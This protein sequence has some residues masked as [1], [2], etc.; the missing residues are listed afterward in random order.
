MEPWL[1][2]IACSGA[3]PEVFF[4][5]KN[6]VAFTIAMSMCTR[7]PVRQECLDWAMTSE[8]HTARPRHGIF[9]GLTPAQRDQLP[10]RTLPL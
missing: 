2:D 6:M 1:N 3:D 8:D 10:D 4:G 5:G 9:G 7:C